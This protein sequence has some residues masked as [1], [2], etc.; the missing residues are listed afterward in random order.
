LMFQAWLEQHRTFMSAKV[1]TE[2]LGV[3][4]LGASSQATAGSQMQGAR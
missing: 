3:S 1:E 2:T 4:V